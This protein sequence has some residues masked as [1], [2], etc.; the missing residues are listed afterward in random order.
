MWRR[1]LVRLFASRLDGRL[2]CGLPPE[3]NGLVAAR[4]HYL[5][6]PLTR[7]DLAEHWRA[8]LARVDRPPVMRDPRVPLCHDRIAAAQDEVHAMLRDLVA[9]APV[10]ARG[11][12]MAGLLLRDGAGPLYNHRSETDLGTAL[13]AAAAQLDPAM[14]LAPSG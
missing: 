9:P 1:L 12:A 4:A 3:T 7:R 14:A 2:A 5:V 6:S 10:A 11:V 8:V 13:R